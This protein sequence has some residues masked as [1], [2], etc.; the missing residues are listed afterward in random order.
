MTALIMAV[1]IEVTKAFYKDCNDR[2]IDKIKSLVHSVIQNNE[3]HMTVFHEQARL[4]M[5]R[6]SCEFLT[7]RDAE[8][9]V[10]A[11]VLKKVLHYVCINVDC[12]GYVPC[13]DLSGCLDST[14]SVT[15]NP[16]TNSSAS[17]LQSERLECVTNIPAG[18]ALCLLAWAAFEEGVTTSRI[19]LVVNSNMRSFSVTEDG[20][21]NAELGVT[22]YLFID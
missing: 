1:S 9:V 20:L 15:L 4:C 7:E 6:L 11:D 14:V 18:C 13:G 22:V 16:G 2:I 3:I 21:L 10:T 5:N 19:T 8:V 12:D 17:C